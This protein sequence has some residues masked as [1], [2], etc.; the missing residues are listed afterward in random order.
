MFSKKCITVILCLALFITPF[1]SYAQGQK[2]NLAP[3]STS[4]ILIDAN[5]NTVISEKNSDK[6]LHPA[7]ISKIMTTIIAI[8]FGDFSRPY[9]ASTTAVRNIGIGGTNAGI[10][11]GE[12]I[13]LNDLLHMLMLVSANDAANVIAENIGG[14]MSGFLK[15]MNDKAKQIGA[16]DTNFTNPIGLDVG[17]RHPNNITTARDMANIARYA[18]SN[19]KFR[20]IVSKSQFNLRPTNKRGSRLIRSTNRFFRDITYDTS[21]FKING[22]KTGY[23]NA[24]R[25]TGVFSARNNE[26]LE[27]ICVLMQNQNRTN[28]F[29]EVLGLLD[30]GFKQ[31]S[32]HLQKSF[33][34]I[35]YRWSEEQINSFLGKGYISGYGDGSFRPRANA[36]KEE[37]IA[38]IMRIKG[39][40]PIDN[41][42]YWS[43]TFINE[44]IDTGL[45][46]SSWH[47]KRK[48]LISRQEVALVISKSLGDI[49]IPYDEEL[50]TTEKFSN[51]DESIVHHIAK[52]Y[53]CGIIKGYNGSLFLDNYSTREEM[54]VLINQYIDFKSVLEYN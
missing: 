35:R 29:Q 52:L 42:E 4:Y 36:S 47:E 1:Y 17:D 49:S 16:K 34:D 51:L 11:I 43:K 20:E 50:L 31:S 54:I 12:Q 46:D 38:L 18:T 3:G 27:L 21:I 2:L 25:N 40:T 45:I 22:I 44:A 6:V 7:S 13:Y 14:G 24:A 33:Y 23:T 53:K 39:I 9:T 30:Y 37:F 19:S 28:M 32:I 41:L 26:G 15:L 5:S 48:E 10:I 8:E